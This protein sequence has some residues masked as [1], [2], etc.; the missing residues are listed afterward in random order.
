ME[1]DSGKQI[2]ITGKI[3]LSPKRVSFNLLSGPKWSDG[4]NLHVDVRHDFLG[5]NTVVINAYN[6]N[7]Y[8]WG[9]DQLFSLPDDLRPN[10]E[11]TI[12][13]TAEEERFRVKVNEQVEY[14]QTY[15]HGPDPSAF[16]EYF[17][18]TGDVDISQICFIS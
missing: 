11:F 13:L 16:V 17:D 10:T 14:Y 7:T 12:T 18:I 6:P 5:K 9:R 4:L 1:F 15:V 8:Q 2:S 3:H